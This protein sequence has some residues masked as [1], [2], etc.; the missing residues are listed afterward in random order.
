LAVFTDQI[1]PP[2]KTQKEEKLAN[3]TT[4]AFT[5]N[6]FPHVF[7]EHY[8]V[9][10]K[11]K[12]M[13]K[14]TERRFPNADLH[15]GT[16]EMNIKSIQPGQN[17]TGK[18]S[19][20]SPRPAT[21]RRWRGGSVRGRPTPRGGRPPTDATQPPLAVAVV[22]KHAKAV[23]VRDA[24]RIASKHRLGFFIKRGVPPSQHTTH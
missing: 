1:R 6:Q 17:P 23:G 10:H 9:G 21:Q 11:H 3:L 22:W 19:W 5:I 12:Y 8:F 15:K 7:G 20:S 24:P 4:Y 13:E 14:F 16:R 18:Q 2:V